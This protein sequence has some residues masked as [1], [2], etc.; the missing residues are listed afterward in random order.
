M[1]DRIWTMIRTC[2]FSAATIATV[3][4]APPAQALEVT[5]DGLRNARGD[6]VICI[7]RQQDEGFPNCAK[8]RPWKRLK[9]PA[10]SPTVRF[11]DVPP[12]TYAVSMFHDEKRMGRPQTNFFGMPTSGV[13]LANN[14]RVGPTNRPTF[15]KAKVVVPDTKAI[16]IT[17]KYLF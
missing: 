10:T 16:A 9:A 2:L 12:G 15:D 4:Y 14:P 13:G 17:A 7:W 6:V 8:G 5:V 11:S 3:L 1:G